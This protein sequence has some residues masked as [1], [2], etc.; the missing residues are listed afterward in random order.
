MSIFASYGAGGSIEICHFYFIALYLK[1]CKYLEP[2]S[3]TTGEDR[4]TR[5]LS[6]LWE[7]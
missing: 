2:P 1:I 6:F 4:D 3:S 7:I 5:P